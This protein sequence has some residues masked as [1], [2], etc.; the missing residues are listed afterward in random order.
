MKI[1][2]NKLVDGINAKSHRKE[3][4]FYKS[5]SLISFKDNQFSEKLIVRFY[6]S[7]QTVYCCV[8]G[9][10]NGNH[11]NGSGKAGGYGYDKESAAFSEAL[12]S[13]GFEVSSLAG[14]GQ[15]EEAINF[16]AKEL[17]NLEAFTIVR[18]HA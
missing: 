13:A 4:S 6:G 5:L 2:I 14:T 18:A 11:F 7:G 16:I 17:M 8:W 12:Q 15:N 3:N 10:I 9:S 1:S